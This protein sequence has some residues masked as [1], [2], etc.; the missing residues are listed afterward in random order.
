MLK[1]TQAYTMFK[2]MIADGRLRRGER[3]PSIRRAA[4]LYRISRTTV[5]N[6]YFNWRRK[7]IFT[8]SPKAATLWREVLRHRRLPC[9]ARRCRHHLGWILPATAP[10]CPVFDFSLWQRYIKSA[11]RQRQRLLTYSEPQGEYDL[12]CALADYVRERRNVVT[13]PEHIVVAPGCKC[14]WRSSACC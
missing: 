7:A 1:Y 8:P 3:M 13:A 10:I 4:E 11:L 2:E 14:C 6:A 12:R 9:P 5:Q